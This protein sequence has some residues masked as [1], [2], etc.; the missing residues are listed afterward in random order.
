MQIDP[1]WLAKFDRPIPRYTSYPT[2]PQF[3]PVT[4]DLFIEK[5]QDFDTSDKPLS[6]YIHIPFCRSMCLFCACSVV[7]NRQP[8]R[9][10][11]YFQH[12]LQEIE[13]TAKIFAKRRVVTQLHLGGGTPTSLTLDQFDRLLDSLHR[14]FIFASDAEI[15]IEIDPRTVFADQGEKL[16]HLRKIGFNRVSFGVQDL[17]ADVQEAVKRR[18]SE[19]MTIE[20]FRRARELEF[21]GI[22]IDLIYG[23]PLQ[24][25]ESFSQTAEKILQLKPDRIAFYSYAKVPWLKPHQKA[26]SEKDLPTTQDKFRIYVETRESLIKGGYLAIGMDHFSLNDDPLAKA[27]RDKTLTR[28]FQGYSIKLAEDMLGFGITSIG[29]IQNTY[30]QNCKTLSEYETKKLPVSKG[31]VLSTEDIQRRSLIQK[32][33]CHFE[34]DKNE[35][36]N[37]N[38]ALEPLEKEGLI[39]QTEDKIIATSS[40]QLLIRIVAS[41]FDAYLN[42]GHYSKAI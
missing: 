8:E 7:L 16:S 14:T 33:M 30:F 4:Q 18:Q 22:N 39:V 35:F 24:T 37:L 20:T 9:Q 17:D 11:K 29:F 1:K 40:G 15:S 2:A 28:N 21:Q 31:Y 25:P 13:M 5:L 36:A 34:L 27:Y 23:L 26:I 38:I 12:L 6:L 3:Y 41:A 19:E 42:K 32:L 10:E